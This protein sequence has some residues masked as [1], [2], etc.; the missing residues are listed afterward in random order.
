MIKKQSILKKK[1]FHL[2][3]RHLALNGVAQNMPVVAG[4]LVGSILNSATKSWYWSFV[5]TL[6]HV[7]YDAEPGSFENLF[8][9]V[10]MKLIYNFAGKT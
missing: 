8:N 9:V 4:R 5:S 1:R 10:F 6:Y 7:L 2:L 3:K